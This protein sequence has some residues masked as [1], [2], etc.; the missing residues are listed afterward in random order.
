MPSHKYLAEPAN[1]AETNGKPIYIP[2]YDASDTSTI[3]NLNLLKSLDEEPEINAHKIAY[4][5]TKQIICT[6]ANL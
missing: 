2:V 3:R 1:I 4:R 5:V 6:I